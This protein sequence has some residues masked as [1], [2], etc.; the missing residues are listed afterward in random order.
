M[1]STKIKINSLQIVASLLV[2]RFFTMLVAIPNSEFTLEG[3][4]SLLVP[5]LSTFGMIFSGIPLLFLMK[6]FPQKSLQDCV[7]I[8]YPKLREIVII[9]EFLLCFA[10]AVGTAS[11]SEFFVST[12]LY[13]NAPRFWVIFLF[14]L[15]VWYSLKMGLEALSRISLIVCV[16]IFFS[17]GL[18]FAGV[19][20]QID[21][22]NFSSPF[23][24]GLEKIFRTTWAYWGQNIEILLLTILQPYTQKT[25]YKRDFFS[26]LAGGF[27]LTEV[28]SFFS[29]AV[30]G[31][32]GKTRMF[33]IYTLAS[34][35]GHGFF[36]R[37]DYLHIINWTFACVLRCA[38][39]S[40]GAYIL[41]TELFPKKK[42]SHLLTFLN[43]SLLFITY[44]ISK[45]DGSYQWIYEFFA[46]GMPTLV[47][48]VIIPTILLWKSRRNVRK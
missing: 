33:P 20:E 45:F 34:L 26:F 12:A 30:L 48:I 2:C 16:L 23:Y 31:I 27:L 42:K 11:Q 40:Y 14:I 32:Y 10:A 39:F 25:A 18:I 9:C 15:T 1:N 4:G 36:S 41:L 19:W 13:P 7:T 44:S 6:K 28:I 46:T 8:C 35:S 29:A 21:F 17:F 24:D 5:I 47:I 22:L 38:L 37:L 3:S 43:I